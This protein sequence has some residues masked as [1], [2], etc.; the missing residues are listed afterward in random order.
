MGIYRCGAG[1]VPASLE[2][3]LTLAAY[4]IPYMERSR[5]FYEAQGFEQAYLWA[6]FDTIPFHKPRVAVADANI[7]IITTAIMPEDEPLTMLGRAARSIPVADAPGNFF[8]DDLSWDKV[9]THTRDRGTYFPL[10]ALSALAST[11]KIGRIASRFHFVPT[12]FSQRR[13]I[14]SDAPA[15]L[16]ACIEDEVDIA[17]LVPL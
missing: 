12:E 7:A 5:R 6:H 8:T 16:A 11:G 14:E 2:G 15:I 17:L 13:T 4:H 9:T 10:D 1:A 3:C